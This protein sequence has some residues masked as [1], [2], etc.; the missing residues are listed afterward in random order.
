MRD[1]KV[2]VAVASY[3]NA[4]YLSRC[5]NSIIEQ[6]YR[7]LDILVVD[8]GSSDET[9]EILKSFDD[10]RIRCIFKEN[11][12]LSSSRQLALEKATGEFIMFVDA[13]DYLPAEAIETLVERIITT[14]ADICVCST[15]IRNSSGEILEYETSI[16]S[17]N[18][19]NDIVIS[20]EAIA[21]SYGPISNKYC[22]SDSW[23][24]LY[25]TTFLYES[26]VGFSMPKGYNGTDSIFN[27]KLL[28]HCPKIIS[29]SKVCYI[30]IMYEKSAVHRK[31]R[32]IQKSMNFLIS[33]LIAEAQKIGNNSFIK[34]Q[35]PY[36]Y[37]G[38]LRN[39][40]IDVMGDYSDRREINAAI[41]KVMENHFR[42]IS[43][44]NITEGTTNSM[45][46]SVK[47]F[48]WCVKIRRIGLIKFGIKLRNVALKK[49]RKRR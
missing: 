44:N 18:E 39:S 12:G 16:F 48:V 47:L 29:I 20:K 7:K 17:V 19:G 25:K 10:N 24:K 43:E 45:S 28:L 36:L 11:G 40:I 2:T 1:N 38:Y 31:H 33:E 46:M 34:E 15:E 5:I 6:S 22:M 21:H 8:D 35:I 26:G 9:E 37:Y 27:H 42:F 23:D 13:D 4:K 49:M 3:N 32:D 41:K 30:H 14:N